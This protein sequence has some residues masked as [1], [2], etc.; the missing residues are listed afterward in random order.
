MILDLNS[1]QIDDEGAQFLGVALQS[2]KVKLEYIRFH[3][4]YLFCIDTYITLR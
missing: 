3:S 4:F 2:N 1:N